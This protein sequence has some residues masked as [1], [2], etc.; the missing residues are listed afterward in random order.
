MGDIKALILFSWIVLVSSI[1]N[2]QWTDGKCSQCKCY[3][4]IGRYGSRQHIANCSQRDIISVPDN[5]PKNIHILDLS[6]NFLGNSSLE[7]LKKYGKSLTF[8]SLANNNITYINESILSSFSHLSDLD[9]TG[10]LLNYVGQNLLS[11]L[12]LRT[13]V[14]IYANMF[15]TKCFH[16]HGLGGMK[17]LSIVFEQAD[18]PGDIFKY[19]HVSTLDVTFQTATQIPSTLFHFGTDSLTTLSI[20]GSKLSSLPNN[21]FADLAILKTLTIHGNRIRFLQPTIFNGGIPLPLYKIRIIGIKSIPRDILFGKGNLKFLTLKGIEDIPSINLPPQLDYLDMSNSHVYISP[22]S[23]TNLNNLRRLDL[24]NT[25]LTKLDNTAFD[26]L[27]SLFSIDMSMNN[28]TELSGEIFKACRNT[29]NSLDLSYNK[30]QLISKLYFSSVKSLRVL[31]LSHNI[32]RYIEKD[33]FKRLRMLTTLNCA[34]NLITGLPKNVF[35]TVWSLTA[36]DFSNNNI[37]ELS[38]TIFITSRQLDSINL[39]NNPLNCNCGIRLIKMQHPYASI[40]GVC[41]SP[42]EFKGIPVKKLKRDKTCY[43]IQTATSATVQL[44]TKHLSPVIHLANNNNWDNL[45]SVLLYITAA[46]VAVVVIVYL[47]VGFKT[48]FDQLRSGTYVL[49]NQITI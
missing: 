18:I 11:S 16:G 36:I 31:N 12:K 42:I 19:L 22:E 5:L 3:S 15:E 14:G 32:I 9:L 39:K 26:S 21:I 17:Y 28:I 23:L 41:T 35:A 48:V 49:H 10:N 27:K 33:S 45:T 4:K 24:H 34:G 37:S 2:N 8:L 30:L 1:T 7:P 44:T 38:S 20:H 6:N 13:L 43:E 47:V 46:V 25:S 40:C 29:L